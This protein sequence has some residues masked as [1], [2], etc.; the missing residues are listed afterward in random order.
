[1]RSSHVTQVWSAASSAA[2][3]F[4]HLTGIPG[5]VGCLGNSGSG[6]L[7]RDREVGLPCSNGQDHH[8]FARRSQAGPAPLRAV[9]LV[10][11]LRVHHMTDA[12][13]KVPEHQKRT[14][15]PMIISFPN[16]DPAGSTILNGPIRIAR[17]WR[18]PRQNAP[19][20]CQKQPLDNGKD[21]RGRN[22]EHERSVAASSGPNNRHDGVRSRSP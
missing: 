14:R 5:V 7:A 15:Y 3:L 13:G 2:L 6:A 20:T 17:N 18:T 9:G 1:L 10:R 8:E 19:Q 12:T 21:H 4:S 16:L 22:A 11:G